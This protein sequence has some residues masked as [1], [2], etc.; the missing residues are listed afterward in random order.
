M[1]EIAEISMELNSSHLEVSDHVLFMFSKQVLEWIWAIQYFS[2]ISQE[3]AEGG[4]LS[5]VEALVIIH[6]GQ[7][8]R[9]GIHGTVT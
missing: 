2:Q 7:C 9:H 4:P 1:C 5:H 8:V 6:R 3:Y